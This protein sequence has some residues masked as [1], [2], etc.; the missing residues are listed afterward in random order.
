MIHDDFLRFVP[1]LVSLANV[2]VGATMNLKKQLEYYL[3]HRG[4]TAAELSRIAGVPKQ[5][6]CLWSSGSTPKK[7]DHLKAVAEAFG[8]TIDNLL[9]GDGPDKER[10]Q[11]LELEH[12]LGSN[13]IG[14]TFE[15]KL[16]KINKTKETNRL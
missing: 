12:L 11:V 15:I 4:M 5:S 13:W 1:K 3:K 2:Q 9:F 10:E 7:L 14:G 6:L 16:R 8:T